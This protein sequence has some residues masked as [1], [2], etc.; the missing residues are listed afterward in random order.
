MYEVRMEGH[1][2]GTMLMRNCGEEDTF[3]LF[4]KASNYLH[5]MQGKV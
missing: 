1:G 2:Q 5:Q 3:F 4:K